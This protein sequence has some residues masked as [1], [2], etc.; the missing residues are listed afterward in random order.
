MIRQ[1]KEEAEKYFVNLIER[2][3]LKNSSE[4]SLKNRIPKSSVDFGDEE[5][6]LLCVKRKGVDI[7]EGDPNN[8]FGIFLGEHDGK[9]VVA[10]NNIGKKNS[11]NSC[12]LFDNFAELVSNWILD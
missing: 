7:F 4:L 12:E 9:L 11:F 2:R 8:K 10:I 6:T 1:T 3:A 5:T